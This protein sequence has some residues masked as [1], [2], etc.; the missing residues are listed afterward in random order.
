LAQLQSD[1]DAAIEADEAERSLHL[2][3]G[4]L[5]DFAGRVRTSLDQLD[6]HGRREIIRAVARHEGWPVSDNR[7]AGRCARL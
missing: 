2:V 4:R 7:M 6:W 3:I 5:A 1:R